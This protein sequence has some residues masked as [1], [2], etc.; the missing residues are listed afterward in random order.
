MELA[1]R[2]RKLHDEMQV[3]GAE[4]DGSVILRVEVRL[5]FHWPNE[6]RSV[7]QQANWI[8]KTRRGPSASSGSRRLFA[9]I[10]LCRRASRTDNGERGRYG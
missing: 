7:H 8:K 10:R 2:M 4:S 1:R 3:P 9:E 6:E 5:T